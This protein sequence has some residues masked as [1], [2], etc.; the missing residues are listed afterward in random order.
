MGHF[1]VVGEEVEAVL[2]EAREMQGRLR[3]FG[4]D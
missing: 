2:K 4:Q 1:T 3:D